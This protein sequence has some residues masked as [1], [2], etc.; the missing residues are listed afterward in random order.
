MRQQSCWRY[1]GESHVYINRGV[2]K[3]L[4]K[5]V[6]LRWSRCRSQSS[7]ASKQAHCLYH[8]ESSVVSVFAFVRTLRFYTSFLLLF[9]AYWT[10][11]Q[12]YT[13][14]LSRMLQAMCVWAW[15]CSVHINVQEQQRQRYMFPMGNMAAI[16][17]LHL[18]TNTWI[19][20]TLWWAST[21]VAVSLSHQR[22]YYARDQIKN[23][24]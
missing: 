16:K 5:I 18:L 20:F 1:S 6:G 22:S 19:N 21:P 15:Q 23:E 2:Y 7:Q 24:K 10:Y 11:S 14:T 8:I 4:N 17:K 3:M 9:H 13:Q 12:Q